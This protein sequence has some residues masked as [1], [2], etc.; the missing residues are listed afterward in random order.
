M[1]INK[2][3]TNTFDLYPNPNNGCFTIS[4]N[5]NS[6]ENSS[7]TLYDVMGKKIL[8]QKLNN[9]ETIIKSNNL[10][11]GIYLAKISNTNQIITKKIIIK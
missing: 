2:N 9:T 3:S 11:N 1:S 8:S 4:F 7:F 5:N 6:F 10:T